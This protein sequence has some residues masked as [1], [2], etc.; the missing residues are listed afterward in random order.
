MILPFI[1]LFGLVIGSFLSVCVYRIPFVRGEVVGEE[2]PGENLEPGLEGL[3]DLPL[4]Y[5]VD[6]DWL[7]FLHPR[8]SICPHC[9]AT[10]LWWHNIPVLSWFLLR[11]ACHFCKA[12]IPIRY[13]LLEI[14]TVGAAVG[15]WASFG[16]TATAGVIFAFCCALIVISFID[17]DYYIIP[18]VITLPGTLIGLLLVGIH[19]Y[20]PFLGRP[21]AVDL[22]DALLGILFGAGFLWVMSVGYLK[23][24]GKVGMGLGDVKLLMLI[25]AFF[26]LPAAFYTIFLGSLLGSV[27]G[28]LLMLVAGRKFSHHLPFG[29]YLALGALTYIFFGHYFSAFEQPRVALSVLVERVFL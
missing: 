29:P 17:I 20:F 21:L 15:S 3:P 4:S 5:Q 12:S 26:G 1:V 22:F 19:S 24:R 7:S 10:L 18:D 27:L 6:G 13:P 14:L 8:R 28:L 25:G 9:K 11:G 16:L 2:E 23:L